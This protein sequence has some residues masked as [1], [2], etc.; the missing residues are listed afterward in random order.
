MLASF[1]S[2]LALLLLG[3]M[4]LWATAIF[5]ILL[6]L[7]LGRIVSMLRSAPPRVVPAVLAGLSAIALLDAFYLAMLGWAVL[8]LLCVACF[9]M[10]AYAHRSIS[11]T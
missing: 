4:E 8:S 5:G 7:W 11:G 9:A 10:T 2:R 3:G 6:A 1:G